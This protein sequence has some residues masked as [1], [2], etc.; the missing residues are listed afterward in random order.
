MKFFPSF[1]TFVSIGSLS[2][3]WYAIC[4][5]TGALIA[6]MIGKKRFKD[7]GY[8]P[9]ILSD[10]LMNMLVIG[11]IGARIWYV[12][13]MFDEIYIKDPMQIFAVWN[14]GLAIHGGII[15]GFL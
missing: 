15:G 3:R 6:L 14:G 2:I 12:V 9:D 5:L 8:N 13:F 4:I 10:F 7:K 11:I 1:N